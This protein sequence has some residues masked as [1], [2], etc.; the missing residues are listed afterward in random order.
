MQQKSRYDGDF[1]M[2]FGKYVGAGL[3]PAPTRVETLKND[4]LI[5]NSR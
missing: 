5:E 4:S 1:A 3:K 2:G